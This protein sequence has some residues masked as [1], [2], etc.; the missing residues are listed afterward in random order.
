[1]AVGSSWFWKTPPAFGQ[2]IYKG[3]RLKRHLS[4][5]DL[6]R[7]YNELAHLA[8][9]RSSARAWR[10]STWTSARSCASAPG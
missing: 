6:S 3:L 1:M 4:H 8:Q 5:F 9:S 10:R 7:A 2:E